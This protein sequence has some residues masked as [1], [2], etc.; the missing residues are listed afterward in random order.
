MAH[1][2]MAAPGNVA[3]VDAPSLAEVRAALPADAFVIDEKRSL[4]YAMFSLVATVAP[5]VLAYRY[6]PLSLV[7]LPVWVA[8][9]IVVGT[10]AFGMWIIAHEC[11]H[12]A[13]SKH[14]AVETTVGFLFH[15]VLLV[16]YF[17]WQRSHAIHHAK[18]NHLTEGES[19]V[20][21][22]ADRGSGQLALRRHRTMGPR[23]YGWY[24]LVIHL[25]L[26]WPIY[27]LTGA[28]PSDGGGKTNHFWP[29][30]PFNPRLFPRRMV[31]RVVISALGV[32]AVI[33]ALAWWTIVAG[34]AIVVAL[35]VGPYLVTNAWLVVYTW[36]HHTNPD[37][38]HLDGGQWTFVDGAFC[39]IDRPYPQVVD[40]LHHRIGTTH[41]V[42]HLFSRIPHYRARSATAAISEAYPGLYRYDPTPIHRALWRVSRDCVAATETASGWYYVDSDTAIDLR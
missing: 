39:S 31:G 1:A 32:I 28:V 22:R 3:R 25:L 17:S 27:L 16:P 9:A 8:V 29:W 23:R 37:T 30:S 41:A 2:G 15:T 26:G 14:R 5:A 34:P 40:V 7:W 10:C 11:G 19:H 6:L 20:P 33:A 13:F 38:P 36:L 42:H 24:N 18:T 12:G 21:V 35:Y 4:A